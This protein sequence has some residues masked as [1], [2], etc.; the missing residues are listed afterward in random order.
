MLHRPPRHPRSRRVWRRGGYPSRGDRDLATGERRFPRRPEFIEQER[1]RG[2]QL[3][4]G[5][6]HLD[7]RESTLCQRFRR[8][9]GLLA[10]SDVDQFVER[11]PSDAQTH[12]RDAG[13]QQREVREHRQRRRH[14]GSGH[15]RLHRSI[16]RHERV[17]HGVVERPR[18]PQTRR[19]PRV[20]ERHGRLGEP[21][22]SERAV[23]TQGATED[24]AAVLGAAPPRPAAGHGDPV[25]PVR[26]T[27]PH[28]CRSGRTLPR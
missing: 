5:A 1:P 24:P 22:Q 20:V 8:V 28:P 17:G 27:R 2:T 21:A 3:A 6:R 10:L 14:D 9:L 19:V 4:L 25:D 7:L 16:E 15:A 12:C 18:P 13:G 11:P 26:R 23:V